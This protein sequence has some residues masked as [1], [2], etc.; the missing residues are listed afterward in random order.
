MALNSFLSS[1][2]EA[3]QEMSTVQSGDVLPRKGRRNQAEASLISAQKCPLFSWDV[4]SSDGVAHIELT[5][6]ERQ[7]PARQDKMATVRV[8]YRFSCSSVESVS[9]MVYVH[10]DIQRRRLQSSLFLV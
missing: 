9:I 3:I 1:P 2:G 7:K 5:I 4:L 8:G 10:A 6:R